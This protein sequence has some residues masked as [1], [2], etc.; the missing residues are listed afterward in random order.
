MRCFMARRSFRSFRGNHCWWSWS[1]QARVPTPVP[2][3]DLPATG[4]IRSDTR[5]LQVS[6][7]RCRQVA[8][9]K[10]LIFGLVEQIIKFPFHSRP[11]EEIEWK[12]PV[13]FTSS[14]R[15]HEACEK[16]D[17]FL[18]FTDEKVDLVDG[19]SFI[20]VVDVLN[21]CI[22]DVNH[23]LVARP[24][25]ALPSDTL[26]DFSE[27]LC[28]IEKKNRCFVQ[29]QF[30]IDFFVIFCNL[31]HCWKTSAAQHL[32]DIFFTFSSFSASIYDFHNI[33]IFHFTWK[34][35]LVDC[36]R[37]RRFIFNR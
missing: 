19:E 26:W 16:F 27:F 36:V 6:L 22:G 9:M 12:K 5:R 29:H 37:C 33:E 35:N 17:R 21:S 8:S 20:A 10:V 31:S 32:F 1:V 7:G 18:Y 4:T 24:C 11:F 30:G 14:S 34:P 15:E 23:M 28:R 25:A 3:Q 13:I 2:C